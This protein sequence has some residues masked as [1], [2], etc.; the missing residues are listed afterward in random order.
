MLDVGD[1]IA[2]IGKYAA[3]PMESL[4]WFSMAVPAPAAP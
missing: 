3:I 2:S 1:G 4:L